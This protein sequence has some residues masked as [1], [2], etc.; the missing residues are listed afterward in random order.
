[1]V[2]RVAVKAGDHTLMYFDESG[3]A[4]DTKADGSPVTRADQEAEQSII[5]GLREIAGDI[6]I[7]A[8]ESVAAGVIPDLTGAEWFWLVDPL[9]GTR[10]FVRG[11]GDYSVNIALIHHHEPVLGV[12]YAPV[13]GEL[14]AGCGPGTA[15][16]WLAESENEK[17]IHVRDL[18]NEG[19]TVVAGRLSKNPVK[20]NAFIEDFKVAK[21][22]Q[23]GSSLK[24]CM[25]AAGKA[26]LYPR[27]GETSEWDTAA[28]DAILRAAGGHVVDLQGV[29]LSYGHAERKFANPPFVAS[30]G[31]WPI[32]EQD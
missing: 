29:P 13:P 26:D 8:E 20:L 3:Y 10:E 15:L 21:V 11:S 19:L 31:F 32:A 30:S 27:F 9:D 12:I 7:V 2:R 16:R 5:D 18:P 6:P 14:Y 23:K 1:M 4:A 25:I 22:L 24:L 17:K 28:G